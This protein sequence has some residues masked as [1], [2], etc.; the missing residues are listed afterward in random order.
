MSLNKIFVHSLYIILFFISSCNSNQIEFYNNIEKK[1]VFFDSVQKNLNIDNSIPKHFNKKLRY[2]FDNN[3]KTNG[4]EGIANFNFKN[5]EFNE[6][7]IEKGKKV[8]IKISLDVI[9]EKDS[10][11]SKKFFKYNFEEYGLI[12]GDYSILDFE[13]LIENVEI[14]ILNSILENM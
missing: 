3:F 9:I 2:L 12:E 8:T 6:V 4:F 14:N 7:L 5:Y 1:N 11:N 13:K 10:I